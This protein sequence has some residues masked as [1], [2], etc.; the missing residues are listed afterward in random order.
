MSVSD[1]VPTMPIP[2]SAH[3]ANADEILV[4]TAAKRPV[5]FVI[6]GNERVL[7]DLCA[8]LAAEDWIVRG[9]NTSD[10]FFE[11]YRPGREAC[12]VVDANLPE[13]GSFELL[14]R[15][16]DAAQRL[17]L[18]FLTSKN[19]VRTAVEA[20]KAGA[21]D[22]IETPL[23]PAELVASIERALEN[24][25]DSNRTTAWRDAAARRVATLTAR[26][27][28]VLDL[29]IAGHANK[30][31]AAM[32]GISQRSVE[33]HRAAIMRRARSKSLPALAQLALAA[34][35]TERG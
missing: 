34:A 23:R 13:M 15:L 28:Q 21:A 19:D 16:R 17:P 1:P 30:N 7:D 10:A 33:N 4:P 35:A 25:R 2:N 32:L 31:I 9:C 8:V 3:D 20:I 22:I 26:Q 18:I 12:L 11:N 14:R 24:A 27:R 6:E 29:I 5:I